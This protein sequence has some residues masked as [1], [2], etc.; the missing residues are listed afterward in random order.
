MLQSALRRLSHSS[1]LLSLRSSLRSSRSRHRDRYPILR[2]F[3]GKA[4]PPLLD[5]DGYPIELYDPD[6]PEALEKAWDSPE[7]DLD[8]LEEQLEGLQAAKALRRR[9]AETAELTPLQRL[10]DWDDGHGDGSTL[11]DHL[12]E[13]DEVDENES[14]D[15]FPFPP[16]LSTASWVQSDVN[17]PLRFGE[18]LQNLLSS[19]LRRCGL[20]ARQIDTAWDNMIKAQPASA[21]QRFGNIKDLLKF[22][23]GGEQREYGAVDTLASLKWR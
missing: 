5:E 11:M 15:G 7:L 23:G 9:R 14:G 8:F 4:K 12:E 10:G 3:A 21:S 19:I 16:E 20:S 17:D 13:D 2:S 1:S 6:D 22:S 18:H